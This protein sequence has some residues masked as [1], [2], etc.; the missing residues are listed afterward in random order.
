MFEVEDRRS[1]PP[2]VYSGSPLVAHIKL[3]DEDGKI[4]E[5]VLT[6]TQCVPVALDGR[7]SFKRLRV[8]KSSSK[9]FGWCYTLKVRAHAL[10][11]G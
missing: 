9:E 3:L 10:A 11:E 6:G 5:G 4:V 2:C 7:V 1:S 8:T